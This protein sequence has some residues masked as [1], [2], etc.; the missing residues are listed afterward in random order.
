MVYVATQ[1]TKFMTLS[2]MNLTLH[3]LLNHTGTFAIHL[4]VNTALNTAAMCISKPVFL[5]IEIIKKL[6]YSDI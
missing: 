1:M 5:S 2:E 4:T 3:C 6:M